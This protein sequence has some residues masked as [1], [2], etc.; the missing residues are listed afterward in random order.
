MLIGNSLCFQAFQKAELL[1]NVSSSLPNSRGFLWILNVSRSPCPWLFVFTSHVLISLFKGQGK[2]TEWKDLGVY[3]IK[4]QS[5]LKGKHISL[6]RKKS[7]LANPACFTHPDLPF[8]CLCGD[9]CFIWI[10]IKMNFNLQITRYSYAVGGNS[11]K[12]M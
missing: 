12:M 6:K 5:D 10:Y 4:Q 3:N 11:Y 2:F 8:C 9:T 7:F 1:C